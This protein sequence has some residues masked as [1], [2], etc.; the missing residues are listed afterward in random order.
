MP[1]FFIKNFLISNDFH[2]FDSPLADIEVYQIHNKNV[3]EYD[4]QSL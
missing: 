1:S 3:Q 4:R 2:Q